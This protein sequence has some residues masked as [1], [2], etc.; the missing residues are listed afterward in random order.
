[1]GGPTEM[2]WDQDGLRA[3]VR[4]QNPG[5]FLEQHTAPVLYRRTRSARGKHELFDDER[6]FWNGCATLPLQSVGLKGFRL[7]DWFPRAPGVYWSDFGVRTRKRPY[8]HVQDDPELGRIYNPGSKMALIEEGGIGTI[9]LRPRPIDGADCFI[10][11]AVTGLQCAGGVPLA[12]PDALMREAKVSWGDTVDVYGRVRFLQD[13]GLDDPAASVHHARP[14]LIV[15]EEIKRLP[16]KKQSRDPLIIT[17]VVLFGDT[18]LDRAARRQ[19]WN[20]DVGYTFVQVAAGSDGELD[21]AAEWIE[22]YATKHGGS[23]ITNF[24]EQRP[25]F[26]D[27]PLSYQRLVKKT[28]DR[29]IIQNLHVNGAMIVDRIDQL[30]QEKVTVN[31]INKV[32]L[33]DGTVIHGDLVVATSIKDSFNR[34]KESGANKELK[35][36]LEELA[37]Q[38]AA[39]ASQLD[40]EQA[41]QMADDLESLTREATRPKPRRA[42]WELSIQGLKDAAS[43]VRDIGGPVLETATKLAP[44]LLAASS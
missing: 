33:G 1:M 9:R 7:T 36:G 27:A 19:R 34:V 16:A 5:E 37:K 29:T 39:V 40:A 3:A 44:L 21:I 10:A 20:G 30:V 41:K 28:Y 6:K 26:A 2:R 14:L 11:S 8:P 13:V 42:F 22:K 23:V 18:T 17:P 35:R 12:V 32:T 43:A 38:V 25:A 24:D 4:A 15:A 31:N